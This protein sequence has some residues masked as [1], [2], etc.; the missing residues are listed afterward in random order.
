MALDMQF[1]NGT[2]EIWS[3]SFW[4]GSTEILTEWYVK[5][6]VGSMAQYG[7]A[8]FEIEETLKI[9]ATGA[10]DIYCSWTNGKYW[11]GIKIVFPFQMFHM[12]YSPY[13]EVAGSLTAPTSA[14]A[15]SW[16]DPTDDNPALP[17]NFSK[18]NDELPAG[19]AIHVSP[20]AGG[21]E[22][23]LLITI[24]GS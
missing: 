22:L 13:Y 1:S 19:L 15:I 5:T 17:Y 6:P 18:Q 8:E 11:F 2:P 12:G 14:D 23:S 24:S 3:R 16:R 9:V 7:M 20:T 10:S 4:G 21:Q